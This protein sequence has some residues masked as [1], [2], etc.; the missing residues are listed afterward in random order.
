MLQRTETKGIYNIIM[1]KTKT[2]K[3]LLS[4][5]IILLAA[6]V[7]VSVWLVV[8][9]VTSG[10]Y[11]LMKI[12]VSGVPSPVETAPEELDVK[13]SEITMHYAKYGSGKPLILLHGNGNDNKTLSSAAKYLA[14]DYTVY[15]PDSRCHGKSTVTEK[16]SYDLM[17]ADVAEFIAAL[18]LDKPYVIGHSDGGITALAIAAT[19]PD[20]LGGFIAC[21]ANS[22]PEGLKAYFT[23]AV[24][25]NYKR[26]GSILD[27]LM[28]QEPQFTAERLAKITAPAYIVAGEFDI[29][30]LKDT[31]FLAEN[32]KGS[33]LTIVKWGTHSSYIRNDGR[34]IY[35]LAADFFP[36]LN[37]G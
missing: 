7:G 22:V 15:A 23:I 19:Y 9:D 3:A 37:V 36:S 20:L 10:E 5:C 32:V 33:R 28:L 13:L 24:G 26:T 12:D 6:V 35:A 29:V 21:G 31:V 14:N 8:V 16:I 18:G 17:A 1:K 25:I 2:K 4:I 30:K 27:A 11:D 34:Q